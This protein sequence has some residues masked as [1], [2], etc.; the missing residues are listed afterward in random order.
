MGRCDKFSEDEI[1]SGVRSTSADTL[2]DQPL[3]EWP[4]GREA[5]RTLAQRTAAVGL[6]DRGS[7][8]EVA[9]VADRPLRLAEDGGSGLGGP[10]RSLTGAASGNVR[11]LGTDDLKSAMAQRGARPIR[12]RIILRRVRSTSPTGAPRSRTSRPLPTDAPAP[13]E[14]RAWQRPNHR[15]Q[16]VARTLPVPPADS[17]RQYPL[18]RP[19]QQR[20]ARIQRR[21]T[22]FGAHPP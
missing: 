21:S 2:S 22:A 6:T 4:A 18:P 5:D 15:S 20:S 11:P 12:P 10:R 9:L 3:S 1:A 13:R 14:R 19:R 16:R 8:S 7:L 17:R